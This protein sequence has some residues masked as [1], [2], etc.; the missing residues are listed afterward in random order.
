MC[1]SDSLI[2]AADPFKQATVIGLPHDVFGEA[3]VAIVKDDGTIRERQY[4]QELVIDGLGHDYALEQ[5]YFLSELAM[6]DFPLNPTG[7]VEK[8]RLKEAVLRLRIG[9]GLQVGS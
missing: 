5:V 3:P 9:G 8:V 6:A 1:L 2:S 7:K 4:Y